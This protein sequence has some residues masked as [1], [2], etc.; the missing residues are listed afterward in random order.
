MTKRMRFIVFGVNPADDLLVENAA[1]DFEVAC[2]YYM[3]TTTAEFKARVWDNVRNKFLNQ[4]V[5]EYGIVYYGG[6]PCVH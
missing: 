3:A 1:V 2:A 4:K 6:T 5:V